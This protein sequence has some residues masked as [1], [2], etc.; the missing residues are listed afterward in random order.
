MPQ[1]LETLNN[2]IPI[3][4]IT[5]LALFMTLEIWVPYFKYGTDRGRQRWRNVGMV[6]IAFL[7]NAVLGGLFVMP[8]I[9]SQESNFGLLHRLLGQSPFAILIGIFMIDL[10][11]YVT[12]VTFHKVPAMWRIH[13]VHH[14]DTELDASSG[15]RL[16]PF[17]L[18]LLL[19][20]QAVAL[21]LLGVSIESSI[22]YNVLA[23]PWFLLNHSNM[24]F[25]AWF[26]RWGSL[27]MST[28]DWH[29]VHHSRYQPER[30]RWNPSG[31]DWT[32]FANRVN[33]PF[34]AF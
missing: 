29:R 12:H 23:L 25:P 16:H 32:G 30:C 24:K 15:L 19:G 14:G 4:A 21:P 22:L 27:L 5:S 28:P 1:R 31:S 11:L 26:E 33:K 8:I 18:M 3:L 6:A 34:G 2:L 20:M 10:L 17:E 7:L 9:W 13:P